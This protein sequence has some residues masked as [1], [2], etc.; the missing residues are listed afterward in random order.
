M[1]G[2]KSEHHYDCPKSY[3]FCTL[4]VPGQLIFYRDNT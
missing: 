2:A 4:L 1:Q 3:Y